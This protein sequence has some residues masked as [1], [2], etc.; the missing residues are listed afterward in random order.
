[1]IERCR[2]RETDGRARLFRKEVETGTREGARPLSLMDRYLGAVGGVVVLGAEA[3]ALGVVAA[4]LGA[5]GAGTP[6][7]AL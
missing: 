6:D 3:G 1:M 4:G 7:C 2:N 5:A